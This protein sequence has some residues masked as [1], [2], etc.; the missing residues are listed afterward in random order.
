M[1]ALC[2]LPTSFCANC[3]GE[4]ANEHM[5]AD[6]PGLCAECAVD[7]QAAIEAQAVEE[8][9]TDEEIVS[10]LLEQQDA[11]NFHAADPRDGQRYA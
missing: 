8:L 5:S 9:L 1:S 7:L 3:T 2:Q 6:H 4:C 10:A 11:A